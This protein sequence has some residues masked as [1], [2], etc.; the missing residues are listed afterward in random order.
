MTKLQSLLAALGVAA[1]LM[2][3][4]PAQ[5]IGGKSRMSVDERIVAG[6]MA[7][8]ELNDVQ[9]RHRVDLARQR[10][11]DFGGTFDMSKVRFKEDTD[12][13]RRSRGRNNG[14][15]YQRGRT[16]VIN[17]FALIFG[18]R[19]EV[20]TRSNYDADDSIPDRACVYP[21]VRR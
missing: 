10:C 11:H 13:R 12:Y 5:A 20:D 1:A 14:G 17:P 2:L 8:A 21:K 18:N 19:P 3:P 9:F 6:N 15:V 4:Q 16:T 7:A